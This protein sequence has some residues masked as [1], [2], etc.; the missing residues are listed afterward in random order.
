MNRLFW[1]LIAG[2]VAA[3]GWLLMTGESGSVFGLDNDRFARLV[4]L[5]L[6][7]I[8]IGAVVLRSAG[9]FSNVARSIAIWLAIALALVAGYQYRFELQDVASRVTGGL[10]PGSP[11]A[12]GAGDGHAIMV[13]RA[14]SGHFEVDAQVNGKPL[15]F[16]VDTGATS[17]VL[18]ESDAARVGIDIGAL[19][20][21]I[22]I[23]TAN[24][25]AEAARARIDTMEI[26]SIERRSLPVLVARDSRLGQ[27]LLGM[28]YLNTLGGIDIR[29]DRLILRD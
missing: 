17:T 9:R 14:D 20:Y 18:T 2:I 11:I 23:Q 19:S 29:R 25:R 8:A 26:G 7:G 16:L 10:V 24:G 13:M 21:T 22:P 12:L 27:S 5:G 28:N 6:L 15:R 4:Y 1:F 3:L